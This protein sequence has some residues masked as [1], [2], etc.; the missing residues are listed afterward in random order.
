MSKRKTV[1][2]TDLVR[3][4]NRVLALSANTPEERDHPTMQGMRRGVM[5]FT[6]HFLHATDNYRGFTYQQ[7]PDG[8]QTRDDTLRRYI[9]PSEPFHRYPDTRD[10]SA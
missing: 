4:C 6:E 5:M 7:L 10:L 1:K 9:M 2:V 3:E 8:Q